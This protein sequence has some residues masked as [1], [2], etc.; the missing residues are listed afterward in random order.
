MMLVRNTVTQYCVAIHQPYHP[1]ITWNTTDHQHTTH[2]STAGTPERHH[3][4]RPKGRRTRSLGDAPRQKDTRPPENEIQ[5][6]EYTCHY[7][8]TDT[9]RTSARARVLP[10]AY[11]RPSK[12]A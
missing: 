7:T 8:M 10:T 9:L 3:L 1:D 12:P 2:R 5:H 4:R 11:H 6:L